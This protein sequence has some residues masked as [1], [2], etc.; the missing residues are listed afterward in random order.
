MKKIVVHDMANP[1]GYIKML[2]STEAYGMGADA[3]DVRR[4][5][6]VGPPTSLESK[7]EMIIN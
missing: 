5:I 4:I 1:D 3:P 2:F 6:H 7:Y